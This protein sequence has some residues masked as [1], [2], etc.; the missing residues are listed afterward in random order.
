MQQQQTADLLLLEAD[1][2]H[3]RLGL[4]KA[5]Q[6]M[7]GSVKY[8]SEQEGK[9]PEIAGRIQ[10]Q[11]KAIA[12]YVGLLEELLTSYHTREMD[13]NFLLKEA[14]REGF[15]RGKESAAPKA[16]AQESIKKLALKYIQHPERERNRQ[17]TINQLKGD[18]PH[19]F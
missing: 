15:A 13:V 16:Q 7:A 12:D 6:G 8:F 5:L 11:M 1:K 4:Q 18:M 3:Y 19:L 10:T 14:W 17:R 2:A 9:G